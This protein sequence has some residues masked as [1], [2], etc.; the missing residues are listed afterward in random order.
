MRARLYSI[1]NKAITALNTLWAPVNPASSRA[2][3]GTRASRVVGSRA[4]ETLTYILACSKDYLAPPTRAADKPH[5]DTMDTYDNYNSTTLGGAISIDPTMVSLPTIGGT[6]PVFDYVSSD[7]AHYGDATGD[8]LEDP[9]V[10]E[11]AAAC[12]RSCHKAEPMAYAGV[13]RRMHD[14][15]MVEWTSQPSSHPLGLF[16]VWKKP[17]EIQR[18]IVDA[19]PANSSFV[20]PPYEH[21]SGD[22]L[23]RMQVAPGHVMTVAKTD[24]AD[25]YHSCAVPR[26]LQ[27][28]FVLRPVIASDLR[29]LGIAVPDASVDEKGYTHPVLTTLPM[30]WG[31]APGIAQGAHESILYGSKGEGSALTRSLP[32]VLDPAARWSCKRVP[33]LDTPAAA[34][35]HVIVI[36]DLLLFR[37]VPA[38]ARNKH[39]GMDV[40]VAVTPCLQTILDRY[41]DVG[42]HVK[43][44]KVHDYATSQDLLGYRLEQN[45]LRC[46]Q[47][48]FDSIQEA[49][50]A[51][52]RRRWAK[53]REVEALVGKFTHIFLLHRPALSV[54]SA[55]YIFAQKVGARMARVWPSVLSELRT[56]LSLLPLVRAD[57]SRQVSPILVQ[58]DA[59]NTGA[60]A[61]YTET[62]LPHVLEHEYRRP[63]SGKI[64]VGSGDSW[65]VQSALA[66]DFTAPLDA[67]SWRVAFARV[68]GPDETRLHINAKEL[69]ATIDAVRWATRSSRTRRCRMV[70]QSDSAVTV[71]ILRKGRSSRRQLLSSCR[72][73]AAMTLAEEVLLEPRW[74]STSSNMADRPSRGSR[75]PGPCVEEG[76]VRPRGRVARS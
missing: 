26:A 35:P 7:L 66:A 30:G 34:A 16:A 76:Y 49:V 45:V 61:V 63:R 28:F 39:V 3:R 50:E 38:D 71:G 5:M 23:A 19:R 68:Y 31:P 55:V 40:A 8:A 14:A 57:L 48:K 64:D 6:F 74:V 37:Q 65:T 24:L 59:C 53:P 32:A 4:H 21:T 51:L 2:S 10:A 42:L 58:T 25:F 9:L 1:A 43:P 47:S 41:R 62:I 36:D 60:A 72:R 11:L 27:R 56:A 20:K 54:F 15:S 46:P 67:E 17:N 73:L 12:T 29:A 69:G 44:S 13:L 75:T 18:L 33:T 52:E 70:L 22:S